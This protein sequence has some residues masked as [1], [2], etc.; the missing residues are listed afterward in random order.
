MMMTDMIN[1]YLGSLDKALAG[2]D[3]ATLRDARG[4]AEEHLRSALDAA[5]LESS[6]VPEDELVRGI[7]EDYGTPEE[8][9][10]AYRRIEK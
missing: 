5:S 9:A 8:V 10:D 3:V 6:D 4:D 1:E 7:I 2:A